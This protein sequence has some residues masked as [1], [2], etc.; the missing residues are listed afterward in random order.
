MTSCSNIWLPRAF[1]IVLP[2][3]GGETILQLKATPIAALVT[4]VELYGAAVA[5]LPDP[6]L[7]KKGT[8]VLKP[9]ETLAELK[10]SD[11]LKQLVTKSREL[12]ATGAEIEEN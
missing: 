2:T 7:F 12:A 10:P 4:V 3:L 8:S 11:K 9:G 5:A 6:L 1:R